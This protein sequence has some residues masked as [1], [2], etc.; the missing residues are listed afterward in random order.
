M[1]GKKK[2]KKEKNTGELKVNATRINA[3]FD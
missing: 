1:Q 3:M 2:E